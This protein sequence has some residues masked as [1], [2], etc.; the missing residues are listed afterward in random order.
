MDCRRTLTLLAS[1]LACAAGCDMKSLPLWPASATAPK[2]P[3]VLG[4]SPEGGLRKAEEI[5]ELPK[6]LKPATYVAMGLFHE[7]CAVD[8]ADSQTERDRARE[9][10]RQSY[11]MALEKDPQHVPAY[12]ALA[13]WFDVGGNHDKAVGTL[14]AA[15]KIAPRD[16]SIWSG[17]GMCH[18]RAKEWQPATDALRKAVE[19][20]P[21]DR[22]ISKQLGLCLVRAGHTDD[23]LAAL[24]KTS[25]PAEAHCT[26]AR[27]L[28]HM[29]QNGASLQHVQ[30]ALQHEPSLGAARELLDELEGRTPGKEATVQ[31]MLPPR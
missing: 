2:T 10:A 16:K 12:V 23:G 4:K 14:H 24:K 21:D 28:H 20:D 22:A 17:L 27:M 3:E 8:A 31:S 13:R 15:L 19:L 25:S 26:V 1:V 18:A 9:A 11:L 5:E 30:I 29:K 6:E 7:Q